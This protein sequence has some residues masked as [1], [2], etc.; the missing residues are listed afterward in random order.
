MNRNPTRRIDFAGLITFKNAAN[1]A[2]ITPALQKIGRI[3]WWKL[4]VYPG[5]KR[6]STVSGNSWTS[7]DRQDART[8]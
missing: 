5:G 4:R 7:M 2:L 1:Y 6:Y 8:F 3:D